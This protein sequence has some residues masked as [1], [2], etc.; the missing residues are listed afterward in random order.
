MTFLLTTKIIGEG[1]YGKVFLGRNTATNE[2]CAIKVVE[3]TSREA[4]Q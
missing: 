2:A 1:A 4:V 3:K